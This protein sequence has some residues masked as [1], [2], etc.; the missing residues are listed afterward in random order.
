MKILFIGA[1]NMAQA[2]ISG[3][4]QKKIVNEKDINIFE[5]NNETAN[6]VLKN[7]KVNRQES[8]N[9]ELS[10]YDI[11]F[12]AVKP[13]VFLSFN[14]DSMMKQL[15]SFVKEN[16]LIVSI[17]AGIS[18]EKIKSFFSNL[19]PVIR[20]MPNTPA[21]IGESISVISSSSNV[22]KDQL[23][24]IKSIFN[25]IGQVEFLDEKYID[26]VTG[27]SGSGPAY[28]FTFIEAL[29]QGGV[30]CGLSKEV[31]EKLAIQTVIGSTFMVKNSKESIENLRHKVTS[32]GGTTIEGLSVLEKNSFR[33]TII[34]AVRAAVKR[35]KELSE[36][37]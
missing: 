1:G 8:I 21:L 33:S 18:I 37:N 31:A 20:I 30:L 4:L 17:M 27:L 29:I 19:N 3:I 24:K 2:I 9:S 34:E 14:N 13:Q 23:E 11:I 16:Q 25:S 6:K 15:K 28:V 5:I 10:N 22:L 26:A 7:Y 32:P 12:L 36:K 35:S